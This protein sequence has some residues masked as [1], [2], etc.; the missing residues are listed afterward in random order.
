MAT[1]LTPEVKA[2]LKTENGGEELHEVGSGDDTMVVK[3]ASGITWKRFREQV[4]D[5]KRAVALE[6]LFKS[7]VV[8]PKG[9]ELTSLM[10]RIPARLERVCDYLA[11]LAGAAE[12]LEKKT[13]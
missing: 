1:S 8:W 12:E 3:R 10:N 13:F 2:Q 7:C 4:A 5:S 6:T 9:E 11:E